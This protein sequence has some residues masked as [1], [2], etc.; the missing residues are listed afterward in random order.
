MF[1]GFYNLFACSGYWNLNEMI[2]L[3]KISIHY[4]TWCWSKPT[5]W[6]NTQN[7]IGL[8]NSYLNNISE[9]H[10]E[11]NIFYSVKPTVNTEQTPEHQTLTS[12]LYQHFRNQPSSPL[13]LPL[14]TVWPLT[15]RRGKCFSS[16][17]V[18]SAQETVSV[19]VFV[20]AGVRNRIITRW[21]DVELM[22]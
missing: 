18:W 1:I 15:F 12:D 3:L 22:L 14:V 11:R 9:W 10:S 16:Q 17:D 5:L 4:W 13:R 8:I 2:R 19:F 21:S 20:F 6:Y 7:E